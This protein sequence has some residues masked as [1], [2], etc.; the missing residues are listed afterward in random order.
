MAWARE[1]SMTGNFVD[2]ATALRIGLANHVK[3]HEELLPFALG[4]AESDRRSRPGDGRRDARRL[5]RQRRPPL[6]EARRIDTEHALGGGFSSSRGADIAGRPRSG[7]WP[8]RAIRR[9][10][11]RPRIGQ[12]GISIGVRRR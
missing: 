4:L 10:W 5:G 12:N 8:G 2:A 3:P 9:G 1:M 11:L 7:R 6:A